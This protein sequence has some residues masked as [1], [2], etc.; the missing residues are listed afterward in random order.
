MKRCTTIQQGFPTSRWMNEFIRVAIIMQSARMRL[1]NCSYLL[2]SVSVS[3]YATRST[4]MSSVLRISPR[5]FYDRWW[6]RCECR[7]LFVPRCLHFCLE[8]EIIIPFATI[9]R[10][11]DGIKILTKRSLD[12]TIIEFRSFEFV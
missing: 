11:K 1:N 5:S 6:R 10:K 9:L 12:R 7:D 4:G 2:E 3:I 8:S